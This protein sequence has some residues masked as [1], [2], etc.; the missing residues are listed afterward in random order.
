MSVGS[1]IGTVAGGALG[2]VVPG[3]G[4]A[5]GASLGG[6]L[7]GAIGGSSGGGSLTKSS[8]GTTTNGTSTPNVP[9][10]LLPYLQQ[11]AQSASALAQK[12]Y[13]P[14]TGNQVQ[15][16]SGMQNQA[17]Q[18]AQ[19]LAT[20]NP[21]MAQFQN[22]YGIQQ[23]VANQGLNGL[24]PQ[25]LQNYMNPYTKAV[26]D[27]SQQR[28]LQQY[29]LEK[30]QLAAQQGQ[31]GA[32]GGSRSSLAQGQL[33]SNFEQQLSQNEA[34]QLQNNFTNAEN[35]GMQGLG[36]ANTSAQGMMQG[37]AG[38]QT[39][40]L[41][42]IG[43]LQTAGGLEQQTGQNQLNAQYQNYLTAQA[44][45]YQQLANS[46]N[47]LN[48]IASLT[49]GTNATGFNAQTGSPS[50]LQSAAGL[51]A[52]GSALG[53]GNIFNGGS[54][55][56]GGTGLGNTLGNMYNSIATPIQDYFS[57]QATGGDSMNMTG[58]GFLNGGMIPHGMYAQG[59][60]VSAPSLSDHI[61]HFASQ[62]E[63]HYA[64]GGLVKSDKSDIPGIPTQYGYTQEDMPYTKQEPK[65][66]IPAYKAGGT[67]VGHRDYTALD[68]KF[69]DPSGVPYTHSVGM[70]KGGQIPLSQ[71]LSSANIGGIKRERQ[72]YGQP[73]VKQDTAAQGYLRPNIK[74][75][76]SHGGL[77]AH[78]SYED[79]G[80]VADPLANNAILA[81]MSLRDETPYVKVK[82]P[83][84][85]DAMV[86]QANQSLAPAVPQ[87]NPWTFAGPAD[88]PQPN[89]MSGD[90]STDPGIFDRL[91]SS[92]TGVDK[93]GDT[94]PKAIPPALT[95]MDAAMAEGAN[96]LNG[97]KNMTPKMDAA[98]APEPK[99]PEKI[100]SQDVQDMVMKKI[101]D[102]QNTGVNMPLLAMGAAILGNRSNSFMGALGA[103][104]DAYVKTNMEQ[105]KNDLE[106]M[107]KMAMANFYGE[108]GQH[109]QNME[110]GQQDLN[111]ARANKYRNDVKVN[112]NKANPYSAAY[113]KMQSLRPD[114]SDDQIEAEL[115]KAGYNPPG[116]AQ[117][118]ASAQGNPNISQE[119]YEALPPGATYLWNGQ[120]VTKK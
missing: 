38:Q 26:M 11:N 54:N 14:Y 32:F 76:F 108:K 101:M 87:D 63:K 75:A 35:M 24:N 21:A 19:G 79:G 86:G 71:G 51:A 52:T 23:N 118:P 37:A 39:A 9:S 102:R 42:N 53:F 103:G 81:D 82:P 20:N 69:H 36:Q 60:M 104:E 116:G 3:V 112:G 50:I 18:L 109:M 120:A 64:H 85:V 113:V 110:Q 92:I 28:Q 84:L 98:P 30:N 95:P 105:N 16:L 15:P 115:K 5:M 47:I 6:A 31:I 25:T 48:P 2:S 34:T 55:T 94:A 100:T 67:V 29:Q 70:K 56:S 106:T 66:L 117:A 22:A 4:T 107:Q 114:L 44:Y 49:T 27:A 1:I 96:Y 99:A 13:Q 58:P 46:Q 72:H 33:A 62:Y 17:G 77:V 90:T 68:K 40:A 45:P 119:E 65:Y 83:S 111:A 10:W 8:M 97:G 43:A 59:G 80:E 41:Q 7:G 91:F 61:N 89:P 12:P 88:Q 93:P 78:Y 57:P 74:N 73:Y